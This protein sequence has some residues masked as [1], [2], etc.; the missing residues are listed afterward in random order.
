MAKT[1]DLVVMGGDDCSGDCSQDECGEQGCDPAP[2]VLDE[3]A[4]VACL[5]GMLAIISITFANG[6]DTLPPE[7]DWT[8]ASGDYLALPA[9]DSCAQI[10]QAASLC[11][12]A[13]SG[14]TL[15]TICTDVYPGGIVPQCLDVLT[16]KVE[17]VGEEGDTLRVTV[18][19]IT[20][21]PG[22]GLAADAFEFLFF[23]DYP[24]P[25][26]V[27]APLVFTMPITPHDC[28]DGPIVTAL[29]VTLL[30]RPC[31]C[32][33]ES[34]SDP[35]T[36]GASLERHPFDDDANLLDIC[37]SLE[38]EIE[39]QIFAKSCRVAVT[40]TSTAGGC[41]VERVWL[42]WGGRIEEFSAPG[43]TIT[44]NVSD[45]CGVFEG[46]LTIIAMDERG[47]FDTTAIPFSCCGCCAPAGG[48]TF[49]E[50]TNIDGID[51]GPCD[52]PTDIRD[53]GDPCGCTW[54][55][56]WCY[57]KLTFSAVEVDECETGGLY[58]VDWGCTEARGGGAPP[59]CVYP[60]EEIRI[61]I[62]AGCSPACCDCISVTPVTYS[63]CAGETTWHDLHGS[64]WCTSDDDPDPCF[65]EFHC[66]PE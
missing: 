40:D 35:P 38:P 58:L 43:G 41:P 7:C 13:D 52:Q 49:A 34:C 61:R 18:S 19:G 53:P 66:P 50:D 65:T 11:R 23:E 63:G 39:A 45:S 29:S 27:G 62:D 57:Y 60:D 17:C 12:T 4:D 32:V 6:P 28:A 26:S 42:S 3:C 24:F 8:R 2:P 5:Q 14:C 59:P 21:T 51:P 1:N 9:G 55:H 15:V 25:V 64:A 48:F 16:A 36:A 47:C 37:D 54:G 56:Q 44:I 46:E 10:W 31:T 30:G 33:D 22:G 20:D